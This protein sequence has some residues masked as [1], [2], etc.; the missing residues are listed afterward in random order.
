[1]NL[2]ALLSIGAF[3]VAVGGLVPVFVGTD[4]LRKKVAAS[5]VIVLLIGLTGVTL[6]RSLE[7][8][9]EIARMQA[10]IINKLSQHE[11]T[12]EQLFA[13]LHYP[14]PAVFSEALL[15]AVAEGKVE[16]RL[17]QIQTNNESAPMAVRFYHVRTPRT[18]VQTE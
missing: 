12:F 16:D 5:I 14:E 18:Q 2:D 1:M 7:R 11:W 17:D 3:A 10:N 9:S 6:I 8:E 4:N 13:E 15:R